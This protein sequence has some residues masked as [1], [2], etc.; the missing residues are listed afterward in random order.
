M[1]H[2]KNYN[3]TYRYST[4]DLVATEPESSD[5]LGKVIPTEMMVGT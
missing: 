5:Q 3:G 1:N 2:K 4:L